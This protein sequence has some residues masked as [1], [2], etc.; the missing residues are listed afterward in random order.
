MN[1]LIVSHCK[2][3]RYVY[4]RVELILFL[5]KIALVI[6]FGLVAVQAGFTGFGFGTQLSDI[7]SRHK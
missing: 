4:S 3:G 5:Q 1:F 6:V 7:P 2:S